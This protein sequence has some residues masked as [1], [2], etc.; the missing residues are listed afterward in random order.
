M[1]AKTGLRVLIAGRVQGVGFRYFTRDAAKACGI[2]GYARNLA[3]GRVEVVAQ[4]QPAALEQFVKELSKGPPLSAVQEC[5]TE[6]MDNPGYFTE[7][8]IRL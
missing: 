7:F 5:L 4:G 6:W 3:D 2:R 8:T 1:N